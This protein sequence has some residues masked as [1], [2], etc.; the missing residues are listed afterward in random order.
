MWGILKLSSTLKETCLISSNKG[1]FALGFTFSSSFEMCSPGYYPQCFMHRIYLSD[2]EKML[3]LKNCQI[4]VHRRGS[5]A[6]NQTGQANQ[7][8]FYTAMI[9]QESCYCQT[10]ILLTSFMLKISLLYL[11]WELWDNED[12]G[13]YGFSLAVLVRSKV[14]LSLQQGVLGQGR[15]RKQRNFL[16]ENLL[17]CV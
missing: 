8:L 5:G 13:R 11:L 1:N 15:G 12:V 7:F 14:L 9:S 3:F 10:S 16:A 2:Q 4:T 17:S 6:T